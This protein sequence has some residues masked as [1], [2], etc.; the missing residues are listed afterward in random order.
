[1]KLNVDYVSDLHLGF[2]IKDLNSTEEINKFVID[3]IKPKV[4]SS[5]LVIAGDIDEDI[6]RVSELLY[7]CSKYYKKVIFVLGNHEYY[8]PVIKYIYTDPMA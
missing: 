2:Y 3:K 7:S 8:I 6:N 1:M 5:V 4:K